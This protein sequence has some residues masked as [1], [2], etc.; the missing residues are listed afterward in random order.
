[1][2]EELIV[3]GLVAKRV[4]ITPTEDIA[5][6]DEARVSLDAELEDVIAQIAEL[7]LR[8]EELAAIERRRIQIAGLELRRTEIQ[9]ELKKQQGIKEYLATKESV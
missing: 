7:E 5:I 9:D 3:E 1:M 6:C 4:E 8:T 2:P